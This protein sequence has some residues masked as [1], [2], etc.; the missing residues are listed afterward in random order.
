MTSQEPRWSKLGWRMPGLPERVLEA[1]QNLL[2]EEHYGI[3]IAG[4][5]V[6][7]VN[8]S[9][10]FTYRMHDGS[11]LVVQYDYD[12]APDAGQDLT[13]HSWAWSWVAS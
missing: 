2:E 1:V 8:P 10:A 7:V 3:S 13:I 11:S 4:T 9:G 5:M 6:L 12:G